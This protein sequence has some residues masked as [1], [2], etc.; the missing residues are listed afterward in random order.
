[1]ICIKLFL[2]YAAMAWL[3]LVNPA[4]GR[5]LIDSAQAD[6]KRQAEDKLIAAQNALVQNAS[7]Q[8]PKGPENVCV[9][10]PA[11]VMFWGMLAL[12]ATGAWLVF[13]LVQLWRGVFG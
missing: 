3:S 11:G 9:V 13:I 1:M 4:E 7:A 8:K 12:A 6:K 5:D 10:A 2:F